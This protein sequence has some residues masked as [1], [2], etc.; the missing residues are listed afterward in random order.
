MSTSP[1]RLGNPTNSLT[2][3]PQKAHSSPNPD[4]SDSGDL[5]GHARIPGKWQG[6][7]GVGQAA[8]CQ[9]LSLKMAKRSNP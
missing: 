7:L 2:G 4:T 1:R 6:H 5:Q 8:S 3:I 9:T